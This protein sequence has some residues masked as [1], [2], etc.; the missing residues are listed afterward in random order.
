LIVDGHN[1]HYTVELLEYAQEH[2]IIVMAYPPHTTHA[3]QGHDVVL[4]GPFKRYW[5]EAFKE[6]ERTTGE[7]VTKS[8]FL[9][10]LE[11]PF[12]QCFTEKNIRSA[13]RSTGIWPWNPSVIKPEK[14]KLSEAKAIWTGLPNTMNSPVKAIV[15]AFYSSPTLKSSLGVTTH[16]P[17]ATSPV[18]RGQVVQGLLQGTSAAILIEEGALTSDF[19]LPTPQ[20]IPPPSPAP[21]LTGQFRGRTLKSAETENQHLRWKLEQCQKII[22]GNNAQM[23]IQEITNIELKKVI[24]RK[25]KKKPS[26]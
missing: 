6:W 16:L 21:R 11:K 17:E 25:E 8:T 19:A 15:A 5:T 3:L 10:V 2:G 14:M 9:Q 22:N 1:S 20:Y 23:A 13:F 7:K 24:A 26:S 12:L 4:F 18:R